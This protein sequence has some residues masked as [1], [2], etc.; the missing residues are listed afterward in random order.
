LR[1]SKTW[2]KK[3]GG[4]PAP[5]LSDGKTQR[6]FGITMYAGQQSIVGTPD[7]P[8]FNTSA[9]YADAR[10]QAELE[11]EYGGDLDAMS[12]RKAYDPAFMRWKQEKSTGGFAAMRE[13]AKTKRRELADSKL[14]K[15]AYEIRRPLPQSAHEAIKMGL[16][17]TSASNRTRLEHIKWHDEK[18]KET[19]K[20]REEMRVYRLGKESEALV[21]EARKVSP[22]RLPT[23]GFDEPGKPATLVKKA[24]KKLSDE[25][26]KVLALLLD[27]LEVDYSSL[28][29]GL[30]ALDKG[31]M[32]LL[33]VSE[34]HSIL[35]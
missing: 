21:S 34:L 20:Y 10:F 14:Q 22:K 5:P 35:R 29:R 32:G 16:H 24:R 11:E 17:G 18:A 33:K 4:K 25:T 8:G 26:N 6:I 2:V 7:V 19:L 27:K 1:L 9:E 12:K 28:S 30:R 23:A 3:K 13:K 31:G 15:L